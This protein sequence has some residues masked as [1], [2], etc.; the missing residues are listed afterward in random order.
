MQ[1]IKNSHEILSFMLFRCCYIKEKWIVSGQSY[2]ISKVV[3]EQF[4]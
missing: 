4:C 2:D 1:A 3:I